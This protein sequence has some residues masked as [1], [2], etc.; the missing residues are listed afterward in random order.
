M[1]IN[2]QYTGGNDNYIF[3]VPSTGTTGTT[4]VYV[5]NSHVIS[6]QAHS[7]VW[8]YLNSISRN[9]NFTV[10]NSRFETTSTSNHVVSLINNYSG[11]IAFKAYNSSFECTAAGAGV[12]AL[13]ATLIGTSSSVTLSNC[14]VLS[15]LTSSMSVDITI[16]AVNTQY[17]G[18][19]DGGGTITNQITGAG[20]NACNIQF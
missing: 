19:I 16:T 1:Y 6:K 12:Y 5:S 8:I 20:A 17:K 4:T 7:I 9:C 13:Y 10:F 3:N 14:S 18:A 15:N 2:D 11:L